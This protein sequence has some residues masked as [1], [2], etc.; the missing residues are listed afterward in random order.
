GSA[1]AAAFHEAEAED[2]PRFGVDGMSIVG[3]SL[4]GG[5]ERRFEAWSPG[6]SSKTH[7]FVHLLYQLAGHNL[8]SAEIKER[9][10]EIHGYLRLGLP[11]KVVSDMPLVVRIFGSLSATDM[12]ELR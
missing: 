9:L 10:E 12:P 2:G 5:N 8:G 11:W 3:F 4:K 1:L 7:R 6:P